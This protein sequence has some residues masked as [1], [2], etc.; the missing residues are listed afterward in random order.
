MN[1]NSFVSLFIKAPML[2][3]SFNRFD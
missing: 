1:V 3:Q 2:Y